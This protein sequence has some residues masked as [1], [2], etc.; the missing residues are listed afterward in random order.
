MRDHTPENISQKK[1]KWNKKNEEL[2][3]ASK[4]KVL[5]LGA[6]EREEE[7]QRGI[8]QLLLLDTMLL[9]IGLAAA[10]EKAMICN[11]PHL[12]IPPSNMYST[13]RTRML[14]T[15]IARYN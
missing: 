3:G 11:I 14:Y 5:L 6:I 10:G 4:K 9:R 1:K 12:V 13:T 7:F 8:G 2:L 15:S